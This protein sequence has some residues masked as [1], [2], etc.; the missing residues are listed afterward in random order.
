MI[1]L[2]ALL[3]CNVYIYT[4]YRFQRLSQ[5]GGGGANFEEGEEE[6]PHSHTKILNTMHVGKKSIF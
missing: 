4:L 2:L 5:L 6:S 3:K 1:K